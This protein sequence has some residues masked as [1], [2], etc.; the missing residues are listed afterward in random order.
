MENKENNW[1]DFKISI[2]GREIEGITSVQFKVSLEQ[3]QLELKEAE[4]NENYELC[5]ELKKQIDNY[6]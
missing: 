2:G 3:L 6:K 1:S 4:L 5:S